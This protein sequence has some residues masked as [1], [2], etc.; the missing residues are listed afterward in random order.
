MRIDNLELNYSGSSNTGLRKNVTYVSSGHQAGFII[1]ADNKVYAI[2][3]TNGDNDF[4]AA[5]AWPNAFTIS[6]RAGINNMYEIP[7][8]GETGTLVECKANG[9]GAYALFDNGDLWTWGY[10]D[11][12]WCGT[13]S[14]TSIYYPL[15]VATGVTEVYTHP[16]NNSGEC[17]YARLVIKKTD[18]KIYGTG[19]N[20]VY[21]L[22][23]GNNTSRSSFTELT[24]AGTNPLSVWNLG[25]YG[26]HII[27]QKSDGTLAMS[28]QNTNGQLGTNTV[29]TPTSAITSTSA[30]WLNNDTTNRL[31]YVQI[32]GRWYDGAWQNSTNNLTMLMRNGS[33]V[34]RIVGA[35]N[36]NYTSLG[37]GTQ[38]ERR[39][40]TVPLGTW[41]TVQQY[42]ARACGPRSNYVL[43]TDGS[44]WTWGYG[45]YGQLGNGSSNQNNATATQ[46]TTGVTRMFEGSSG[47]WT[48]A[49]YTQSP[50]IE[51]S[52]EYFL[53][54]YNAHAQLG[55]GVVIPTNNWSP[56]LLRVMLPAGIRVKHYAITSTT[57]QATTHMI[58]TEDNEIWVWGYNGYLIIDGG[59]DNA[60]QPVKFAPTML[61]R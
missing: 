46:I 42:V 44:L 34:T 15:Q 33:G 10:N 35:G 29:T 3:G 2:K 24:W 11:Y 26:G 52:G 23:L 7:F 19:F 6:T 61:Q 57:G 12:G 30:A 5:A 13:S 49:Y 59:G 39:V 54:G 56:T 25:S 22:G 31:E 48:Y 58:V 20:E 43:K 36:N 4:Y 1:V 40:P 27:V 9:P 55:A 47:T 18:G 17:F 50:L 16:S 45:S 38:N 37:D 53:A 8:P 28:G 32:G 41:S 60:W 51:K 21:E 14:S